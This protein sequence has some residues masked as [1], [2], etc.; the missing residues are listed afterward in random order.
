MHILLVIHACAHTQAHTHACTHTHTHACTHTHTHACTHTHTHTC[1]H[2]HYNRVKEGSL[3]PCPFLPVGCLVVVLLL[4][5]LEVQ[6]LVGP[7]SQL[8]VLTHIVHG[9]HI[10][11]LVQHRSPINGGVV[12]DIVIGVVLCTILFCCIS[13][14]YSLLGSPLALW[15]FL[16][17]SSAVPFFP[18]PLQY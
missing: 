10:Q 15:R 16:P 18:V 6:L 17:F 3:L 11:P 8:S 7:S 2:T 13:G 12:T 9:P 1:T 4:S 14:P 5:A